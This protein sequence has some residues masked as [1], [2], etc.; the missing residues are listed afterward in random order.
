M[1]IITSDGGL[2]SDYAKE[3]E[4]FV[5]RNSKIPLQPEVVNRP[6]QSTKKGP[7]DLIRAGPF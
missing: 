5:I 6:G 3:Y 1:L 2:Y 4:D 7:P